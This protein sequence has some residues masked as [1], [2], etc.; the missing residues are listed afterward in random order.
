M[1]KLSSSSSAHCCSSERKFDSDTHGRSSDLEV[2][3][4]CAGGSMHK[5]EP[6]DSWKAMDERRL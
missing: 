4:A 1:K 3:K 2:Q 6:E 5:I